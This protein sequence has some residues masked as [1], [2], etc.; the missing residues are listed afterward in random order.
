MWVV[1]LEA[2]FSYWH[3]DKTA[4][5]TGNPFIGFNGF[6]TFSSNEKTNWLVTIRPRLGYAMDTALIYA[7]AARRSQR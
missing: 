5:T 7:T 6:A 4:T 1:G 2:D 3:V